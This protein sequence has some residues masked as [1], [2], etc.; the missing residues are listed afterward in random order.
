MFQF[1]LHLHIGEICTDI[2]V[3]GKGGVVKHIKESARV[4]VEI[5]DLWQ[6]KMCYNVK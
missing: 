1:E 4:K 3:S 5:S 2:L 6:K